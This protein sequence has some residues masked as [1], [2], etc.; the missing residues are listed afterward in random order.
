[1]KTRK[2]CLVSILLSGAFFMF[3]APGCVTTESILGPLRGSE[4]LGLETVVA[5]LKEALRVGTRNAVRATSKDGGY[6]RNAEIRIPM[7]EKLERMGAAL[8]RVGFGG[9]V[10]AFER[11]MNEAAERAAREATPIFVDAI[12]QM[13]FRDAKEIL[14][15]EKTAATD[16]FRDKTTDPLTGLYRPVVKKHMDALGVV[17]LYNRLL[18][19][20]LKIPLVPKPTVSLEEYITA[21]ALAGLFHVVAEEE[22]KIRENPA[23]RTTALLRK[24]FAGQ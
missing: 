22:Q 21:K 11:R 2:L 4:P 3:F 1:V 10:D 19:R 14:R 7:P 18:A 6:W 15:G 8:R 9:R 16:Y 13:T 12:K 17:E 24:V 5:G 20:Y 23:A